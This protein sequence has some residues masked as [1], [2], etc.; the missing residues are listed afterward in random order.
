MPAADTARPAASAPLTCRVHDAIPP[1]AWLLD[2]HA[3]RGVL[4]C[5]S[6][7]ET[8]D[9]AWF[10]GVWAGDFEAWDFD[11][12]ADVFGSGG[13]CR[14]GCLRL[15]T[16]SH[17][18]EPLFLL[19]DG[20]RLRVA[21][22][23]AFLLSYADS[24][25]VADDFGYAERF[26]AVLDGIDH[27]RF[28]IP[29]RGGRVHVVYHF[30][31]EVGPDGALEHVAKPA[32][33]SF[34][35]YADYFDHVGATAGRLLANARSPARHF[36]FEPLA[37]LSKGYDSPACAVIARDAGCSDAVTF[38]SS[39]DREGARQLDDCG[40]EIGRQLGLHVRTYRRELPAH[41][42]AD[43]FSQFF[44][45]GGLGGEMYWL[46]MA[47]DLPGRALIT[48][49]LGGQV[50]ARF[51]GGRTLFEKNDCAGF[52]LGEFRRRLG[53][54][55]IPLPYVAATRLADILAIGRSPAMAP[56]STGGDYD[57]PIARRIAETAGI[58]RTAFG[59]IKT[60]NSFRAWYPDH[61]PDRF[62]E[63]FRHYRRDHPMTV[64]ARLRY[65]LRLA[66]LQVLRFSCERRFLKQLARRLSP[67]GDGQAIAY[68]LLATLSGLLGRALRPFGPPP[69]KAIIRMHPR[70]THLLAWATGH[71]MRRYAGVRPDAA[72]REG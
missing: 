50:W 68:P 30:N 23:L 48:G 72:A 64:T 6:G 51:E 19:R 56:W 12:A 36:P 15:I 39:L 17:C 27:L 65:G 58:P 2:W 34:P 62:Q 54:A 4:H 7:V 14:D 3:G 5:G 8:R 45:D 69:Y 46:A 55:H 71:A 44:C 18:L 20:G 43:D 29:C 31:L 61:W 16:P 59:Q 35:A 66:R 10:E 33:P 9:D 42:S 57:K 52:G 22:S 67:S 47:D 1:L 13:L 21:N 32:A 40:L 38:E 49:I 53:F 26:L 11:R 24:G 37:T 63:A 70:H 28:E 25:I 60:G 41:A